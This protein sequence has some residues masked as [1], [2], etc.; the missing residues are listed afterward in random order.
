MLIRLHFGQTEVEHLRVTSLGDKE[1]GGLDVA[2]HDSGGVR[3]IERIC[4]LDPE[5]QHLVNFHRP[6]ADP[7]LQGHSL[8]KLHRDEGVAILFANIVDGADVGMIECGGS[9]GLP[10][11]SRQRLCISG[12]FVRQKLERDET[13]QPR[14][15]GFVDHAHAA[16]A[17][18]FENPV[19]RNG[20]ADHGYRRNPGWPYVRA[21]L[22]RKSKRYSVHGGLWVVLSATLNL[23]FAAHEFSTDGLPVICPQ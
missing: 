5:P 16:A 14:V 18:F 21:L 11:K 17:Q 9:L 15:F 6:P 20:L 12:H 19:V 1:I 2:V 13:V 3:R 10:S 23:S 22:L 4:N 8:E 7:V